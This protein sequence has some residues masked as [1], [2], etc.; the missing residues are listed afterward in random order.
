[1]NKFLIVALA[2]LFTV[3]SAQGSSAEESAQMEAL[4]ANGQAQELAETLEERLQAQGESAMLLYWMG[5]AELSMIDEASA[6][7]KLGLARS[8]KKNLEKAV[9]LDPELVPARVSLGRYYLEAPAIA[10]GSEVKAKQQA[11]RLITLDP[12]SGYRLEASIAQEQEQYEEAVDW[13][14]Q[15]LA[16]QT[17][18]WDPQYRLVVLAVHHQV[19]SAEAVLNQAVEN[20]RSYATNP[21]EL[22]PLISYQRG[23]LAAVSGDFLE[24]GQAA[25]EQYLQYEPAE[26][27]PGLDW[28]EFRLSQVERHLGLTTE[29]LARLESLENQEIPQDLSFAIRDER[30]WHYSD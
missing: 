7:R 26:D 29:A 18:E 23:K 15:A 22:L 28:A 1:M 11:E 25:L 3:S 19:A 6:F 30:R 20:V 9:A 14:S 2:L 10:G 16:A 24:P 27:E 8:A 4:I 12:P 13:F 5:R 21:D 17:W